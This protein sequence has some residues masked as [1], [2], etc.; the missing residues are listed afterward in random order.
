MHACSRAIDHLAGFA[1]AWKKK[2]SAYGCETL[3]A[4]KKYESKQKWC[5]GRAISCSYFDGDA[6]KKALIKL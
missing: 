2:D 1:K 5:L 4:S 6:H 3:R